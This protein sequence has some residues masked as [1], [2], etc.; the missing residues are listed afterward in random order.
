MIA[1]GATL[2]SALA[3]AV[4][5]EALAEQYWRALQI[6]EP[7]LLLETEMAVV[8]EKFKTYGQPR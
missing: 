2:D 5:V 7:T 4:E 6:G 3:L 1:V 8:L